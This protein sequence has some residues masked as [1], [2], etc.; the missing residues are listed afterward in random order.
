MLDPNDHVEIELALTVPANGFGRRL[1]TAEILI[2]GVSRGPVTEA[3]I[4]I[5]S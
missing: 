1:V 3:L 5:R 2:D 4:E